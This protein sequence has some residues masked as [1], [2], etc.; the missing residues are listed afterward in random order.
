LTSQ[1]A[2]LWPE[3]VCLLACATYA[4]HQAA[5]T[6]SSF[7]SRNQPHQTSSHNTQNKE[8]DEIF[9]NWYHLLECNPPN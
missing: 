5:S 6:E 2:Y 4:A 9:G 7:S 1:S 8:S 3:S